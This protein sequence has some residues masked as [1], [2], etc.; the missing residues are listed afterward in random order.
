M[1]EWETWRCEK[2]DDYSE[3][4]TD[5]NEN[6]CLTAANP[7]LREAADAAIDP[8]HWRADWTVSASLQLTLSEIRLQNYNWYT[9]NIGQW[10][11]HMT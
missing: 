11:S 1:L 3:D 10:N 8:M 6:L 9:T 4:N 2:V 5:Q 7:D